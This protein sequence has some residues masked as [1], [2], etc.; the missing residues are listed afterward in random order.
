M[1][2]L[3]VD[4][5]ELMNEDKEED[6][7]IEKQLRKGFIRKVYG[8]IFFQLLITTAVVYYVM[9]NE[10]IQ[11][12]MQENVNLCLI[13]FFLSIGI[14][15][16]LVCT[17]L[18]QKVPINYILLITFTIL[19]S[20]MVSYTTIYFEPLSVLACAGVTMVVVFGLTMY[21]C[22]TKTDVTLMGGFLLS[23]SIYCKNA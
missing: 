8:T 3:K 12:F 7:Q 14:M 13:P 22:F 20:I 16:L 5:I 4:D 6:Y 9:I 11:K 2:D 19:E 18:A 17:K 21:A 1:A 15:L 23:C 10:S